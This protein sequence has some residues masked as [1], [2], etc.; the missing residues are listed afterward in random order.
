MEDSV[1]SSAEPQARRPFLDRY[2]RYVDARYP[3]D[4]WLFS[5]ALWVLLGSLVAAAFAY[6]QSQVAPVPTHGGTLKEGIVGTPRFVNPVLA[7]TQADHDMV[8]LIYSG[9]LRLETDGKL[10]NHLA[11]SLTISEDGMVYNVVLRDDITFHDGEAVTTDDVA[12][13]V[14]LIQDAELKSPLRG[15]WSG[16]STEVISPR[17]INFVLEEPF[18]PFI[19][20]LAVGILPKHIWENLSIEELP[21]SQNNTEPVG[22]GPYQVTSVK[23]DVS[24]LISEY[25]LEAVDIYN[26]NIATVLL[27][28]YQD[29][30]ELLLALDKKEIDATASLRTKHISTAEEQGYIS[31]D[32]P[33]PRIFAVFFNQNRSAA[34]RDP[35]ARAALEA[36]IDREALIKVALHGHGYPT[37]TPVPTGF[38]ELN[39]SS[40]ASSSLTGLEVARTILLEGGWEQTDEGVWSKEIDESPTTLS[41]SIATAN[42]PLFETTAAHLENTW[43]ELGASV[44]VALFEQAD[45]VQAVIRPRDYEALLFGADMGR[46]LDLYPFW[47]SSQREDPG[48]NVALYTNITTDDHLEKART[49]QDIQVR[50]D[51]VRQTVAEIGEENPAIFLFNPA[52]TY[53]TNKLIHTVPIERMNRPAERFMNISDWHIEEELLWSQFAQ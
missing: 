11:E 25:T 41:I 42:S 12:Y 20:N 26:T 16:V 21:F 39:S 5:V 28:F 7:I 22:S 24:G 4:R 53:T 17:E 52:F 44:S 46:S 14:G 15:S 6:N 29:E 31:A 51:L 1:S 2:F 43:S 13:T 45:L 9:L 18:V 8:A 35:A 50:A 33:L 27:R 48:L 36:A 34:L 23:R 49:D 30:E 3:S 40:T 32:Q 10:E 47:H 19:E 37:N 38:I